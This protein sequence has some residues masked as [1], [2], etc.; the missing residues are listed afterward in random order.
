[1]TTSNV[2]TFRY[3]NRIVRDGNIITSNGGLAAY[4]AA[5]YLVEE[6]YGPPAGDVIAGG[7][8]FSESNL[9]NARNPHIVGL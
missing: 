2:D 9:T 7:L 1:M 4:E 8:V 3:D 5:L 6:L